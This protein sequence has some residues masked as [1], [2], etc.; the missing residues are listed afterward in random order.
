MHSAAEKD[1]KSVGD[2]AASMAG[3][4]ARRS[5][6]Q[7]AAQKADCW[8]ALTVGPTAVR[9]ALSTAVPKGDDSVAH[10]EYY[11]AGKKGAH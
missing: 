5:A 2:L 6:V 10:L 8:A 4:T 11:L 7:R 3:R 9:K 1:E